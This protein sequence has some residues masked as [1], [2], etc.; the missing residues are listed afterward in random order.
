MWGDVCGGRGDAC[1]VEYT[2]CPPITNPPHTQPTPISNIRTLFNPANPYPC[3]IDFLYRS[4]VGVMIFTRTGWVSDRFYLSIPHPTPGSPTWG[5]IFCIYFIDN[6][7]LEG[8]VTG[9]NGHEF[10]HHTPTPRLV[11]YYTYLIMFVYISYI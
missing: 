6:L 1:G 7:N 5:L 3:V 11:T 10:I 2:V 8:R 4:M 9:V